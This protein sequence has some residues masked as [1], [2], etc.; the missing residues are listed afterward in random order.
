MSPIPDLADNPIRALAP[1]LDALQAPPLDAG[2]ADF[3][4]SNLEVV[5]VDVGNPG[6]QRHSRRG[7]AR[8]QRA[9]QR[10]LD[11]ARS[12][13]AEIERRVAAA[14]GGARYD[15]DLRSDQRGRVP[16]PARRRSPISS[17]RAVEDVTGRRPKLSTSGGTSDARFIKNACPV[18]EL[19]LVGATM[20][21]SR[22]ARRAR[23]SRDAVAHLR[24]RAR[25][26]FRGLRR[27]VVDA[28]EIEPAGRRDLAAAAAVGG[29]ERR[30]EIG[31]RS[32]GPSRPRPASRPSSA[33]GDAGTTA[34]RLRMRTSS[35]SRATSSRVK[36]AH[37]RFRLTLRV[38]KGREIVA[39]DQRLRAAS[40]I[41]S[42]SSSRLTRQ[43]RPRSSVSG[44]RRLTM[45]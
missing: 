34:R 25:A 28:R 27:G 38:A 35:P 23:R 21:A 37:R 42:T 19:G 8:L 22:R 16:D 26:L 36:R 15:A 13:S 43:A 39:A 5:S 33:P 41:A 32:S 4:P 6:D 29:L 45:R 2:N 12:L 24:T 14:A 10:S 3:E 1:I 31:A 20:H 11:A 44:A 9:L 40:F 7:A 18:V 17:P 30:L